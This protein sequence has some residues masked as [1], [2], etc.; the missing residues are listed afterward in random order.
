MFTA[1]KF[2]GRL[3]LRELHVTTHHRLGDTV[4]IVI[5]ELPPGQL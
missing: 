1:V 4:M 5:R 2:Q 3:L